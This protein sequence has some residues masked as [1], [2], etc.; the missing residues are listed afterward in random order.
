VGLGVAKRKR[1]KKKCR[2]QGSTQTRVFQDVHTKE[3]KKSTRSLFV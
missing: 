1:A 2:A 3:Y